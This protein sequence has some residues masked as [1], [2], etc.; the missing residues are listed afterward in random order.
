MNPARYGAGGSI[1]S[2]LRRFPFFW[3][4]GMGGDCCS[5]AFIDADDF[6][7]F[8]LISRTHAAWKILHGRPAIGASITRCQVSSDAKL[9]TPLS[10]QSEAT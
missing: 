7:G 8:E 1:A 6:R 10:A 3:A 9:V 2:G 5:R 4:A